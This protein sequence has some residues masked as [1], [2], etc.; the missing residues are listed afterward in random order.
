MGKCN[1]KEK[2]ENKSNKNEKEE[3]L[4]CKCIIMVGQ[5]RTIIFLFT[6]ENHT[7]QCLFLGVNSF[8]CQSGANSVQIWHGGCSIAI[9]D[10]TFIMIKKV[11]V[12]SNGS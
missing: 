8:S 7:I 10:N 4:P 6:F 1:G 9:V 11:I 2:E 12:I 5:P 3:T